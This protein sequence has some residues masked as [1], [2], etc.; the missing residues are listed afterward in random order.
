MSEINYETEKCWTIN[1]SRPIPIEIET[2]F[3]GLRLCA[4]PMTMGYETWGHLTMNHRTQDIYVTQ[5]FYDYQ[6]GECMFNARTREDI[7]LWAEK[8]SYIVRII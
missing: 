2:N 5:S 3:G 6:T 4:E 1:E 7:R 8:Y